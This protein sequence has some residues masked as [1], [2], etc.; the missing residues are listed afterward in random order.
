VANA[1][2]TALDKKHHVHPM[3]EIR[4][5]DVVAYVINLCLRSHLLLR[6]RKWQE[7]QSVIAG[8]AGRGKGNY[9]EV[10]TKFLNAMG[11]RVLRFWNHDVLTE[12]EAI[13]EIILNELN[14][15]QESFSTSLPPPQ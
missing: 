3:G 12:T 2:V 9:D 13:P 10:R 1:F 14:K 11:Y 6:P 4:L 7:N 15:T 8:E 5:V